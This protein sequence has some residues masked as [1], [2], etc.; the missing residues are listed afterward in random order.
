M[1]RDAN[2]RAPCCDLVAGLHA[3]RMSAF[4]RVEGHVEVARGVCDLGE[5][6]KLGSTHE[7]VRVCLHEE[8]ERLVPI[9]ARCRVT[10]VLDEGLLHAV[11]HPTPTVTRRSRR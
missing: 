10:P 3:P 11:A 2:C 6:R 7:T 5:N 8:V 4:P 1:H 9:A